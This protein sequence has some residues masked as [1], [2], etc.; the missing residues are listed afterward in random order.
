M[1]NELATI[2]QDELQRLDAV[3]A[4]TIQ[5][6][7]QETAAVDA[8]AIAQRIKRHLESARKELVGPLNAKVKEIN[9]GFKGLAAPVEAAESRIKSLILDWRRRE[10][11][12]IRAEQARIARENAERERLAREEQER[13]AREAAERT[14]AEADAAGFTA[15]EAQELAQLE[16]A[17]VP[18]NRPLLEV[19]PP[20]VATTTRATLGSVTARMVW[21]FEVISAS[22]V[23]RAYLVVD[24]TAIR[25]AVGAGVRE[26]PGVRIYQEEQLAGRGR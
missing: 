17:E 4:V 24:E 1:H 8:L 5:S 11:A 3:A 6:A 15:D 12:R 25:R 14:R 10:D 26:I 23:P 20:P 13:L 19:A 18:E 21:K 16:A 9:D 22:D 7:E 2:P